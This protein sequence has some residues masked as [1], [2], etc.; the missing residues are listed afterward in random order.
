M[1]DH[2]SKA[3]KT[4]SSPLCNTSLLT[5]SSHENKY[6]TVTGIAG[7]ICCA[8]TMESYSSLYKLILKLISAHMIIYI[9]LGIEL[10]FVEL[11]L[12]SSEDVHVG[13]KGDLLLNMQLA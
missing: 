9:P 13:G 6:V 4:N 8:C 1:H 7:Y 5:T 2:S 11:L 3:F 12:G 10:G